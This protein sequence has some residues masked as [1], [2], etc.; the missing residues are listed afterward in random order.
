MLLVL[1][2][3]LLQCR[4]AFCQVSRSTQQQQ[5]GVGRERRIRL[6]MQS[7]QLTAMHQQQQHLQ[8]LRS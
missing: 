5:Q 3:V 4:L 2:L 1:L 6:G 7:Q 8:P